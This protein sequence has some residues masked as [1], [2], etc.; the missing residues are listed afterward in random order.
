[1]NAVLDSL[2]EGKEKAIMLKR[3]D[4]DELIKFMMDV[5]KT[6]RILPK[7]E[8]WTS[9]SYVKAMNYPGEKP[10]VRYFGS[11]ENAVNIAASRLKSEEPTA[12][13]RDT[14]IR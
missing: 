6:L 5:I 2:T 7:S 10:Y 9:Y 1:M 4:P 13:F 11:F 14:R 3:Y 8:S 12:Y